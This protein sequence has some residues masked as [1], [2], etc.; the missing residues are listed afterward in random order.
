M[1]SVSSQPSLVHMSSSSLQIPALHPEHIAIHQA[2]SLH[3]TGSRAVDAPQKSNTS[4]PWSA[5]NPKTARHI[6]FFRTEAA[7]ASSIKTGSINTSPPEAHPKV[8]RGIKNDCSSETTPLLTSVDMHEHSSDDEGNALPDMTLNR[9]QSSLSIGYPSYSHGDFVKRRMTSRK[10]NRTI[11]SATCR[12]RMTLLAKQQQ[13]VLLEMF[14]D[15]RSS[16]REMHRT[17][18]Y[19]YVAQAVHQITVHDPK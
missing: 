12:E 19:A 16:H 17:D 6:S 8:E 7:P 11:S 1:R 13:I 18:L 14:E 3:A 5:A 4:T 2:S 15:G 9:T 10:I